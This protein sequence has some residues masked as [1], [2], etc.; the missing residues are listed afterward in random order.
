M[1]PQMC[2]N[3]RDVGL[4]DR[5]ALRLPHMPCARMDDHVSEVPSATR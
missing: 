2:S 1:F 4:D 5:C 3:E